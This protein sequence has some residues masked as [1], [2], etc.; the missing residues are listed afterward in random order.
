MG[1]FIDYQGPV[2]V[3]IHILELGLAVLLVRLAECHRPHMIA[4]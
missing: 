4:A 2:V 3:P 1:R